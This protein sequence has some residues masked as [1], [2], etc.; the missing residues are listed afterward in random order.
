MASRVKA[1]YDNEN[2]LRYLDEAFQYIS[3]CI[4]IPYIRFGCQVMGHHS[5]IVSRF[6]LSALSCRCTEISGQASG[7]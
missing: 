4:F 5:L 7:L 1:L 2:A 3:S 6:V